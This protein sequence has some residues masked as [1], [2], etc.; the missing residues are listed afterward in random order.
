MP[1]GCFEE[2]TWYKE[3]HDFDYKVVLFHYAIENWQGSFFKD[4]Q[5]ARKKT[6]HLHGHSHSLST[7]KSNRYDVGVDNWFYY[8]VTLKEILNGH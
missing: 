6:V 5:G 8:P 1:E 4:G 3:I 2:I 7:S